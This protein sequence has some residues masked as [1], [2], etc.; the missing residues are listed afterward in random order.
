MPKKKKKTCKERYYHK[1]YDKKTGVE[2]RR[3]MPVKEALN[4]YAFCKFPKIRIENLPYPEVWKKQLE[5]KKKASD[6]HMENKVRMYVFKTTGFLAPR[7][8]AKTKK[9]AY[10]KLKE[11]KEKKLKSITYGSLDWRQRQVD[12]EEAKKKA[13]KKAER[14]KK[15]KKN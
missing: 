14:K 9:S 12:E 4:S 11:E 3:L 1:I 10:R 2:K 5:R 13:R 6:R 8:Q 15:G 7:K